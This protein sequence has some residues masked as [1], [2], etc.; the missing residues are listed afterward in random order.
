MKRLTN[1]EKIPEAKEALC[2]VYELPFE[3]WVP[4]HGNIIQNGKEVFRDVFDLI[5]RNDQL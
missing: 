5:E 4:T 1:S 2:K 3:S